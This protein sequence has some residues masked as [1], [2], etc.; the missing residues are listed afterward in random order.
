[1]KFCKSL[2]IVIF[3]ISLF[4]QD[5]NN[6]AWHIN[7]EHNHESNNCI[8]YALGRAE[9]KTAGA[10]YCDPCNTFAHGIP[11]YS[12]SENVTNVNVGDIL[13]WGGFDNNPHGD[14]NGD[15]HAAYVVSVP[16][17]LNSSNIGDIRVDQVPGLNGR[18]QT[19]VKVS[20]VTEP[21]EPV[22]FFN[23]PRG[24]E[25]NVTLT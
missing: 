22:G 5:W 2:I 12:F 6:P 19:N 16:Y 8:G 20:K 25:I 1:M 3:A 21:N 15:G 14:H 18:E 13:A 23:V 17:H 4:A 7:A 11:C 24:N 10:P 9:G